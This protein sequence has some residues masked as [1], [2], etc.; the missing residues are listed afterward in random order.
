M[1]NRNSR[2]DLITAMVTAA[3]GAGI[4]TSFAV[5]QGQNP[6]VAL[7]ITGLAVAIALLFE[8]GMRR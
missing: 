1:Y 5:S 6:F 2:S 8:W 7:G 3:V 4:V